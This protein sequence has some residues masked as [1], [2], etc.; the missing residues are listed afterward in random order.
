MARAAARARRARGFGVQAELS[1][2]LQER[3]RSGRAASPLG[4][5]GG[6]FELVRYFLVGPNGRLRPVPGA[7]IGIKVGIGRH[8]QGAVDLAAVAG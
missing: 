4:A 5:G 6:P 2:P 7:P 8:R 3:G 1:R